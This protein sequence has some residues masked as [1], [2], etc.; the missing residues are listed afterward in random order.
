MGFG[1]G[2]FGDSGLPKKG[3]WFRVAGA[4]YALNGFIGFGVGVWGL[5]FRVVKGLGCRRCGVSL[6][7]A[8]SEA[9]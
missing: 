6:E 8:K 5:G 1:V 2:E 7:G 9:Q 4:W 3:F